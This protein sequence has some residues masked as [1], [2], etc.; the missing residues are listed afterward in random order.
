MIDDQL[1]L[2]V[3]AEL[4]WDPKVCS[5]AIAVS[6]SGGTI[7]LRGTVGSLREKREAKKAAE[8][9][10]GV[11]GVHDELQVRILDKD[12]REDTELRG[13]I[14]QALILDGLIPT[15][16]D[17]RVTGGFVTLT[18]TAS[19]Q[20]QR[21]EAK[22]IVAN[23]PGVF[24]IEDRIKLITSPDGRDIGSDI[25]G[26][27]TRS[28]RLDAKGLSISTSPGSVTLSGVVRSWAEHDEAIAAAWAAPG[29]TEVHDQIKIE[30]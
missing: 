22:F 25:S 15:T 11:I 9:V 1:Q 18:G 29:V 20:Y 6:A 21:D 3:A 5:A 30:Y 13:D 8:R 26:A 2:D 16:V 14:L 10:Y 23:V 24:A 12:R 28:A 27:F 19:W 7:T 4:F 17:A